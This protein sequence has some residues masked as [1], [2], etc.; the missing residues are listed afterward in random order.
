M[1]TRQLTG[2]DLLKVLCII[3]IWGS[4][5][6]VMKIGMQSFTPMQLGVGRY[7]FVVFPLIFF[8]KPPKI[9]FRWLIAYGLFQGVGQFGFLFIGLKV[10]MTAAL[11]SVLMQTQIFFTGLFSYL[12]LHEKP[13]RALI[14]GMFIAA[15]GLMSFAMNYLQ[16]QMDVAS[17]TTI[18]GFICCLTAAS[19]WAASG[20]VVKIAQREGSQ[21]GS[22]NLIVWC[23]IASLIPF[24]LLS[25]A[26]DPEISRTRWLEASWQSILAIV[27]LGWFSTVLANGFWTNLLKKYG[28]N[29]ISPFSLGVPVFGLAAGVVFLGES[30]NAWQ[31]LGIALILLALI[32]VIFGYKIEQLLKNLLRS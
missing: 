13:G 12:F 1:S 31:W 15:L 30:I 26:I 3:F 10:G 11:A 18:L 23:G 17:Q 28:P 22:V 9:A 29:Q 19:M 4:N 7:F 14:I 16:P 21:F 24:V 32:V 20:I 2:P 27:Y 8:I 5:F 25:L 6:V